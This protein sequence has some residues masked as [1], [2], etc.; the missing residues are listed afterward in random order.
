MLER[1][2]NKY[3]DLGLYNVVYTFEREKEYGKVKS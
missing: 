1:H 3:D 2:A